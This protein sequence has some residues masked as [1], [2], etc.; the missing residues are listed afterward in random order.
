MNAETQTDE[1]GIMH[2]PAFILPISLNSSFTV[3][4]A[5]ALLACYSF[6][7]EDFDD[8]GLVEMVPT[9]PQYYPPELEYAVCVWSLT[10]KG[11]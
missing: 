9:S 10:C 6:H 3:F 11:S 7:A 2:L 5:F 1:A 8:H 4:P